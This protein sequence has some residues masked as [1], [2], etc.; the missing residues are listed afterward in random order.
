MHIS[1]VVGSSEQLRLLLFIVAAFFS[2]SSASSDEAAP[3][4][5][6]SN[7]KQHRLRHL[8]QSFW[9]G[10]TDAN[11]TSAEGLHKGSMPLPH[12]YHRSTSVRR[13]I[14][15]LAAPGPNQ[16]SGL[17]L[18]RAVFLEDPGRSSRSIPIR[19]LHGEDAWS[20][21]LGPDESALDVVRISRVDLAEHRKKPIRYALFFGEHGRELI[22]TEVGI[23][24]VKALC[25]HGDVDQQLRQRALQVLSFA[26]F[27]LFPNIDESGR[28]A[29]EDGN[30]C[31]RQNLEH[32]DLNRNWDYKWGDTRFRDQGQQPFSE[33]E[34]RIAKKYLEAFKPNV[35]L[36]V[37]SGDRA[38]WTPGAYSLDDGEAKQQKGPV[39]DI[40]LE[41]AGNVN[42]YTRCNCRIGA[43]GK[44][45]HKH[46]PGTSI[47]YVGLKM[48]VPYAMA[49]EIWFGK[50][51]DCLGRY[52][53]TTRDEYNAVLHRWC[54]S[55]VYFAEMAD[56]TIRTSGPLPAVDDAMVA[57]ESWNNTKVEEPLRVVANDAM[58]ARESWNNTKV[59]EP[60][61]IVANAHGKLQRLS[62]G[63]TPS[64][65]MR[66][67]AVG[68]FRNTDAEL[69]V[70]PTEKRNSVTEYCLV[71]LLLCVVF[72][73]G[74][75]SVLDRAHAHLVNERKLG[76]SPLRC[77]ES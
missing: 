5:R 12:M 3:R 7:V 10:L 63:A 65:H 28:R 46:H 21:H 8:T 54:T 55:M 33:P 4:P 14:V 36:S 53:P 20:Y 73:V 19:E 61:R 9:G 15:D 50:T 67:N 6:E 23:H 34:T 70:E 72:C 40:L 22:S 42:D 56:M 25:G 26:E 41:V 45:A 58:V 11:E 76:N 37:H 13:L 2:V 44:I 39:W 64:D 38:L 57:R 77:T 43:P 31:H 30:Y 74:A 29:V 60:L 32:V 17:H 35:F 1:S 49:W 18:T 51:E 69:P 24:L 66:T 52:N 68:K 75:K 48:N 27:L 62:S 16:C 59:E 47:D 71:S